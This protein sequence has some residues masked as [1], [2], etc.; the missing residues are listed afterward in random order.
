M[1]T[2]F[3]QSRDWFISFRWSSVR[4]KRCAIF[5]RFK[6]KNKNANTLD[7]TV[8]NKT[9]NTTSTTEQAQAQEQAEAGVYIQDQD[10]N[11]VFLTN[12]EFQEYFELH[13]GEG[14]TG[15]ELDTCF[16]DYA[17][18]I[19][20]MNLRFFADSQKTP[21]Y[22]R[23]AVDGN[24]EVIRFCKN[25]PYIDEVNELSYQKYDIEEYAY[26]KYGDQIYDYID[27]SHK[28][29]R[30]MLR[31][32]K[33]QIQ[34]NLKNYSNKKSDNDTNDSNDTNDTND[35]ND[36]NDTS[37]TSDT[38]DSNDTNDTNDII[39]V[40]TPEGGPATPTVEVNDNDVVVDTVGASNL[41]N[42]EVLTS[43]LV[44]VPVFEPIDADLDSDESSSSSSTSSTDSVISR[45]LKR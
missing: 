19:D 29:K 1:F 20:P 42:I 17:L 43:S 13:V 36:S 30:N 16:L 34:Q 37:D 38:N 3:P 39:V 7:D 18:K 11:K 32:L 15:V 40:T 45:P 41:D 33:K 6:N 31:N 35:T 23:T 21:V 24:I 5:N 10:G 8:V 12:E 4:C 25:H 44:E 9:E 26:A 2:W 28:S 22:E 27:A 14:E